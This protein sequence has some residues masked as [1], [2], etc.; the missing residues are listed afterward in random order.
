MSEWTCSV[1]NKSR[2]DGDPDYCN[3]CYELIYGE[4]LRADTRWGR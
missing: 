2:Y 3:N 4:R 1:C